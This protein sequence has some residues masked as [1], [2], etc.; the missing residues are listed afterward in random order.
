MVAFNPDAD[1]DAD[2][3]AEG[4]TVDWAA[5]IDGVEAAPADINLD[6][7]ID[8]IDAASTPSIIFD[9]PLD[10]TTT[11]AIQGPLSPPFEVLVETVTEPFPTQM[12]V[13]CE[14]PVASPVLYRPGSPW[15]DNER[16]TPS[17]HSKN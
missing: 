14:T 10:L 1:M 17:P 7:V 16:E 11:T 3:I 8:M 2:E 5:L 6:E 9:E 15:T 13:E 4:V 12:R